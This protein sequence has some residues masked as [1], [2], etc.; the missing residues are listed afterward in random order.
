MDEVMASGAFPV[1]LVASA[2]ANL[3]PIVLLA[4][5]LRA[6]GHEIHFLIDN[7]DPNFLVPMDVPA[8][9][10]EHWVFKAPIFY[11]RA[12]RF[13]PKRFKYKAPTP[14]QIHYG[15]QAKLLNEATKLLKRVKPGVVIVPED[16]ISGNTWIITAAKKQNTPVLTVPY[17]Y[18][19]G[20]DIEDAL[21]RKKEA[22]DLR[23]AEGPLG[24]ELR[25]RYPKWIKSGAF[26]GAILFPPELILAREDLGLTLDNPWIVNGGLS[27]RVAV[28]SPAMQAHYDREGVPRSKCVM[29][30]SVYADVVS[31]AMAQYVPVERRRILIS[32]P[33]SYHASRGHL[34]AFDSY[35]DLTRNVFAALKAT[36]AEIIVSIHPAASEEARGYI[37]AAGFTPSNEYVVSLIGQC[38]V[39]VSCFSST[40]RWAVAAGKPVVNYDFYGFG[41]PD[42]DD[43]PGVV[44][45]SD[46]ADFSDVITRAAKNSV[47]YN[48]LAR[49]QQSVAA[50]WGML[51]GKNF[52]RIYALISE[53]AA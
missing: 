21:A 43:C 11:Q 8:H 41:L 51:D 49:K 3:K 26:A 39:F 42:Y 14:Y 50:R 44:K 45:V 52:E 16:G 19:S 35:A 9:R 46:F 40:T 7:D 53:M 48:D 38:D 20:K 4:E 12:S 23:M 32:W 30:G 28:E 22:N 18:G 15:M 5:G 13:L 1:L 17:G 29:T 25:A 10:L 6:R 36:G 27:D 24:D 34:C 37:A 2:I 31:A 47:Y 33:A